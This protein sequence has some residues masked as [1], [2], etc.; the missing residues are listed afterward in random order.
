MIDLRRVFKNPILLFTANRYIGYVLLFVRGLLVAKFLGPEM[1][2]IWGFLMLAQQYLAYTSFGVQYALNVE[3]S[4]ETSTTPEKRAEWIGT[5]L[6]HTLLILGGLILLGL[7]IQVSGISFFQKYSF[8]RYALVLGLNTG[9][10]MLQDLFATA[11][12]A[13]RKLARVAVSEM[14]SAVVP[15]LAVL[16]FRDESLID[17]LFAALIL[18]GLITIAQYSIRAPFKIAFKFN[19]HYWKQLLTVG[20]PLLVY[21]ASFSLIT[22]SGRTIISIFYPAEIMG[23]YSLANNI[24]AA[25]LLGLNAVS[26]VVFPDILSRTHA[27][28]PDDVAAEVVQ[29]VNNFYGTSVFLT[30]FGVILGLP[31]LFFFIPQYQPAT[32]ALSVLLLA[33]AIFSISFGYNCVAIARKKQMKVAGISVITTI[34]VT[35]LSL[36]AA[37]LKMSFMWVAV[38]VLIGAFV[39]SLWQAHLGAHLLNMDRD[40]LGY[41]KSVLPWGSLAATLVFLVGILAGHPTPMGLF[42][43]AIFV[44]ANRQ[45]LKLL[46]GFIGQKIGRA[47]SV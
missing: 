38:A 15:L 30:V 10:N 11:Y 40:G 8:N 2:G 22:V 18:Q 6:I 7:G 44:L 17:F 4:T 35:G 20:G 24:T 29:K 34:I 32:G 9:L 47:Q 43:M 33:Q 19:F 37:L 12:R 41:L 26:W 23:Y 27:D 25:T 45:K 36:L 14:L 3:L 13:H 46:Q 28:I 5:A 31:V 21:G 42:G 39:Y 16:I 1:F